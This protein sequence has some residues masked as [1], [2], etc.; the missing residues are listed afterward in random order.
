[1]RNAYVGPVFNH[2]ND[3]GN[4]ISYCEWHSLWMYLP[5]GTELTRSDTETETATETATGN[6]ITTINCDMI[7]EPSV[8]RVYSGH[9]TI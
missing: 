6:P 9:L 2:Y 3:R 8:G 5:P 1:M 7:G 4:S